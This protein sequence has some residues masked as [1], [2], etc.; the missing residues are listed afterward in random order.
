MRRISYRGDTPVSRVR[1]STRAPVSREG[2]IEAFWSD[3]RMQQ[4][5]SGERPAARRD[6]PPHGSDRVIAPVSKGG[7]WGCSSGEL[8]RRVGVR[9]E[10]DPPHYVRG[11]AVEK[12]CLSSVDLCCCCHTDTPIIGRAYFRT[13]AMLIPPAAK[14]PAYALS[15]GA[16]PSTFA[17]PRPTIIPSRQ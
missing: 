15:E 17:A 4:E 9:P 11:I 10:P 6:S 14:I 8:N 3:P 1:A 12:P 13:A 16:A 2:S 7:N 5:Y